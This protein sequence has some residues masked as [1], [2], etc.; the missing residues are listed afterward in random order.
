MLINFLALQIEQL[1]RIYFLLLSHLINLLIL[2][3][4]IGVLGKGCSIQKCAIIVEFGSEFLINGEM[5][6]DEDWNRALKM[7]L[8]DL[9]EN[10]CRIK[11]L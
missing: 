10:L 4:C 8:I 1:Y 2:V 5:I 6:H 7:P 11:D 9:I 3:V